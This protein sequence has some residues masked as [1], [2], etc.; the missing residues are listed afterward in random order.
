MQA[1]RGRFARYATRA[2]VTGLMAAGGVA[3]IATPAYAAVPTISSVVPSK[4]TE[5]QTIVINGAGFTG[6]VDNGTTNGTAGTA[7]NVATPPDGCSM[8]RFV[9]SANTG[10]VATSYIVLSD[11][12]I[13]VVVPAT[14]PT[15]GSAGTI[16]AGAAA[17]GT[18]AM[19]V[20]VTNTM[21]AGGGTSVTTGTTS[22]VIYR[23]KITATL[24][25]ATAKLNPLGGSS[26]PVNLTAG[27]LFS[28]TSQTF[29]QENITAV[30]SASGQ[31]S[32]PAAVTYVSGSQVSVAI[33]PG[34]P[35]A[36]TVSVMLLHD[37]FD[38]TADGDNIYP[39][40]V[41]RIETCTSNTYAT[42]GGP[43]VASTA[44]AAVTYVKVFGKGLS[45]VTA[46]TIDFGADFDTNTTLADGEETCTAGASDLY[47][48]C[49]LDNPT[50]GAASG[51]V[52]VKFS[53]GGGLVQ[54]MTAGA[55]LL[56]TDLL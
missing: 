17:Q 29:T 1:L 52:S 35:S 36:S 12:K 5:L 20:Q 38:G 15:P 3:V 11:T 40:V 26:V 18:G 47:F 54:G 34:K 44:G 14:I 33:P 37:G 43:A 30:V 49:K 53:L 6:M 55:S 51:S 56:F 39:A 22:D 24:V 50:G 4:F 31:P 21:A 41:S 8:V 42:C 9:G 27:Q 32:V 2:L 7:C 48:T 10:T 28:M 25:T 45:G 19:E 23:N 16:A 46:N 13:A